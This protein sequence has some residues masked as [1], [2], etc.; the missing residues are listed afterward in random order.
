MAQEPIWLSERL[1]L[2]IHDI[3]LSRYHGLAGVRDKRQ[4]LACIDRPKNL[5]H[6]KPDEA[7][8]TRL[9]S[10]YGYSIITFHPF[11]DGNKRTGYSCIETF[12]KLN[13]YDINANPVEKFTTVIGLASGDLSEEQL[14]EWLQKYLY[15]T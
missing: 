1:I 12:L 5:Y 8:L 14:N 3:L 13:G 10:C 6:Y 11:S 4:L 7:S 2:N 9:A 15:Q